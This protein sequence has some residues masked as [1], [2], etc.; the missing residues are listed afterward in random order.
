MLDTDDVLKTNE[1]DRARVKHLVFLIS[2]LPMFIICLKI[3]IKIFPYVFI[4]LCLCLIEGIIKPRTQYFPF[5]LQTSKQISI[6]LIFK[7]VNE[8]V[9]IGVKPNVT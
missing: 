2:S 8:F 5:P 9:R 3:N 6:I 4:L 7:F 1:D